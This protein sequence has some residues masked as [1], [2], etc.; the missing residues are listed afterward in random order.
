MAAEERS[1][2]VGLAPG[3][4]V[5]SPALRDP[6]FKS[7]LVLMAEHSPEGAFGLVVNRPSPLSVRDL[8]TTVS[9]E[10]GDAAA[11][12]GRD[13]GQVLFGGPVDPERLWIVHRPGPATDG[14]EGEALAP[15][16]ALGGSRALLEK[17]AR[18]PDAG[19]YLLLLGY[20]G[21]GPMQLEAEM[22]HG[23][24]LPLPLGADLAL[25]L[26]LEERWDEAVR[27]LGLEPAGFMSGGG[28][29]A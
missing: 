18:T 11:R 1:A 29:M 15:G 13:G 3:F 28:A 24:W 22:T 8:L 20:A 12:A 27:R 5:A 16:V 7:A 21:W 10:L 26:P 17:L 2:S 14:E 6:N 25:D 23:S 9:G 4:L 19:P